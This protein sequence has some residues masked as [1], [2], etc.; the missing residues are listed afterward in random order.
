MLILVCTV[1]LAV[2]SF[3]NVCIYRLPRGESLAFPPSRCPTCGHRLT[4]QDLVP[5]LSY[6]WLKGRCRYCGERISPQYP[7]VEL[8]AGGLF[9]LLYSIYGLSPE[10]ISRLVLA[11]GLLVAAAIDLRHYRIPN[12]LVVFLTVAAPLLNLWTRELPWWQ[13][14]A[15]AAV[16]AG[17]LGA[18]AVLS[19]GGM[20]EGDVKLAAATGL[21][22]GPAGQVLAIF[23][24]AAA[25]AM[26]GGV[27]IASGRKKRRD[28]IP[29]APF[30]G[31]GSFIAYVWGADLW[32][33]YLSWAG[34][35]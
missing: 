28:P 27:L 17:I 34:L 13:V 4:P 21:Y 11:S 12:Q 30:L 8:G 18:L 7:L 14:L 10:L 25:G 24:A 19:R 23:L 1:G 22:L 35:M 2:G 9:G 6:L 26:V 29:F 16:G 31:A 32:R 3:L 20:G 15:G 33:L 5:V